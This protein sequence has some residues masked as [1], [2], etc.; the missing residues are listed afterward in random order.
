MEGKTLSLV[1]YDSGCVELC[2]IHD[3]TH[4]YV[5]WMVVTIPR[6]FTFMTILLYWMATSIPWILYLLMIIFIWMATPIPW[7]LLH[8]T[9]YPYGCI[10]TVGSCFD[11]RYVYVYVSLICRSPDNVCSHSCKNSSSILAI[12]PCSAFMLYGASITQYFVRPPALPH[13]IPRS[14]RNMTIM[15]CTHLDMQLRSSLKH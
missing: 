15:Q 1:L 6:D 4:V 3:F 5:I 13:D 8:S 11:I 12:T 9:Y 10:H 7:I 2:I 14:A